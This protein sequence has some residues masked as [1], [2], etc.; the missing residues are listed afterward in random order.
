MASS[1]Y[2]PIGDGAALNKM[3]PTSNGTRV[4]KDHDDSMRLEPTIGL[5]SGVTINVGCVIGSGIF[6]SPKGVILNIGSVGGSLIIWTFSGFFSMLGALCFAELGLA[7]PKSGGMYAYIREAFGECIAFLYVW[8]AL[9]ILLPVTFAALGIIFGQY[10]LEPALVAMNCTDVDLTGCTQILAII[11]VS[12]TTYINCRS[13][14]LAARVQDVLTVV[15]VSALALII[16]MGIV[17]MAK[18][19]T[20]NFENAF[21]GTNLIGLGGA[22]YSGLFSYAGWYSLNFIVEEI[23]DAPRNLP[24]AIIISV[25]IVTGIYVLANVAYFAVLTPEELIQSNAVAVTFGIKVLGKFALIMPIAVAL[26]TLGSINGTLLTS[27]RLFFA[28]ARDG[29]LPKLIAM[30]NVR[31]KTPLPALFFVS[32]LSLVYVFVKDVF[33]LINYFNFVTWTAAGMS[34]LGLLYLRWKR[35]EME[36]P[37]KVNIALPIVFVISCFILVV[38][39]AIN[40]P[41]DTAIGVAITCTGVPVYFLLIKPPRLPRYMELC[42]AKFSSFFQK[43]FL[44]APEKKYT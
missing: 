12:L 6:V 18:G 2:R 33:Q 32:L 40:A 9:V 3:L 34:V 39:G 11:C 24:R 35:P 31:Y 7:I 20:Q 38:L 43:V 14:R 5:F 42:V 19:N 13:V 44:V 4:K 41:M 17:E 29:I 22:L 16:I 21:E 23:K 10:I 8:L 27:S 30:I 37:Y 25:S 1:E 28:G 15:K 26:S 36:K